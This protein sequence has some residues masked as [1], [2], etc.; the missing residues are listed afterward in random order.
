MG[1]IGRSYPRVSQ[2]AQAPIR[3][4]RVLFLGTWAVLRHRLLRPQTLLWVI[5]LLA[6]IS[7]S[8]ALSL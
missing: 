3:E 4:D 7:A 1:R 6:L 2:P 5:V 8:T